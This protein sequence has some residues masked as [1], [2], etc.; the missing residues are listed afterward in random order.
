[1]P[2][3]FSGN[4]RSPGFRRGTPCLASSRQEHHAIVVHLGE[5]SSRR[6]HAPDIVVDT[7]RSLFLA[8]T[9]R[10]P[11]IAMNTAS[12]DCDES[13]YILGCGEYLYLY[14]YYY[15]WDDLGFIVLLHYLAQSS[16]CMLCRSFENNT[17][18]TR[19]ETDRAD[20]EM[21]S[22]TEPD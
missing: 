3:Q 18:T 19:R 10:R 12:S 13:G 6:V 16:G 21:R 22:T 2:I 20:T 9:H 14:G 1:M 15:G 5:A 4:K 7:S 8:R 11:W 17:K